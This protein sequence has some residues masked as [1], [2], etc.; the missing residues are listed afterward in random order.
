MN[1]LP[2]EPS[3]INGSICLSHFS[4]KYV[5]ISLKP[6]N[7]N[8]HW[9]DTMNYAAVAVWLY[10]VRKYNCSCL[11]ATA[12]TRAVICILMFLNSKAKKQSVRDMH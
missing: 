2:D 1:G 6:Y 7:T 10:L 8:V 11:I 12:T 5:G 9:R 4:S 3:S